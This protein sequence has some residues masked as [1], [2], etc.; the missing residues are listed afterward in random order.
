[1]YSH[2]YSDARESICIAIYS[3]ARREPMHSHIE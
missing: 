3:D 2:I 1:M